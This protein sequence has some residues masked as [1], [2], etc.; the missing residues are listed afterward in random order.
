MTT[1]TIC[2]WTQCACVYVWD[3]RVAQS[4]IPLAFC[5]CMCVCVSTF[6]HMCGDEPYICSPGSACLSAFVY[7]LWVTYCTCVRVLF[8]L[9]LGVFECVGSRCVGVKAGLPSLFQRSPG[10]RTCRS[11]SP[12]TPRQSVW[13]HTLS[14]HMPTALKKKN[15]QQVIQLIK[16]KFV[17]SNQIKY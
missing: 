11:D 6:K 15:T 8:M 4:G 10:V 7:F 5:L 9:L 16:K 2:I 17:T 13:D 1:P 12:K 14:P 3:R